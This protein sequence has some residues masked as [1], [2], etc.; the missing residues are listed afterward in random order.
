MDLQFDLRYNLY[1]CSRIFVQI[2]KSQSL[3]G[4]VMCQFNLVCD[5]KLQGDLLVLAIQG[6]RLAHSLV[7]DR[8]NLQ[9]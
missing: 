3:F 4:L 2:Q 8:P 5:H 1:M 9:S 7:H 6:C